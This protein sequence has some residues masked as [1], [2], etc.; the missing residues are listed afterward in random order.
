MRQSA[1]AVDFAP[2]SDTG[3]GGSVEVFGAEAQAKAR[4]E[5]I[6]AAGSKISV[7][8]EYDY[9]KGG[10][11][12]RVQAADPGRDQGVRDRAH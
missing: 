1:S 9:V 7:L 8:A 5:F 2:A 11:V 6:Q 3:P 12:V 10:V 4:A